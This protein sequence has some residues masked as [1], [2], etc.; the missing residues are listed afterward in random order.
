MY[1]NMF[2]NDYIAASSPLVR[3]GA[4]KIFVGHTS[5]YTIASDVYIQPNCDHGKWLLCYRIFPQKDIFKISYTVGHLLLTRFA[6]YVFI[7]TMTCL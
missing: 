4:H 1:V 6:S 2:L 7:F 3:I 5:I